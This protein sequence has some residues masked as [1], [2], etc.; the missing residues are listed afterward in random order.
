MVKIMNENS[1]LTSYTVQHGCLACMN[2]EV[3]S[4]KVIKGF[5]K[6]HFQL[7]MFTFGAQSAMSLRRKKDSEK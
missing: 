2:F 3:E 1:Q 7:T 5:A 4:S 6:L